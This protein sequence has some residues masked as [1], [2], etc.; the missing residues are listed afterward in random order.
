M[1]S[2]GSSDICSRGVWTKSSILHL[3][4]NDVYKV[5]LPPGH[6]FPMEKYRLVREVRAMHLVLNMCR[7]VM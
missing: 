7:H 3:F 5:D 1:T 4:Y 6:R 2:P